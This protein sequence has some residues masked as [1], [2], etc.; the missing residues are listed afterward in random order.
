MFWKHSSIN[1]RVNQSPHPRTWIVSSY[2]QWKITVLGKSTTI[3]SIITKIA[4]VEKENSLRYYTIANRSKIIQ[5]K[6]CKIDTI[7]LK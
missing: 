6:I 3:D 7:F 5:A 4:R 2:H 1:A